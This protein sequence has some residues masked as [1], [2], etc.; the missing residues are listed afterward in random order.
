MVLLIVC[1]FIVRISELAMICAVM[2]VSMNP[3][4]MTLQRPGSAEAPGG[5]SCGP[6]QAVG[7][8]LG[9]DDYVTKPLTWRELAARIQAGL[10]SPGADQSTSLVK[11][12]SYAVLLTP[13][14][15][16]F[17]GVGGLLGGCA[18]MARRPGG[19]RRS[20]PAGPL[21]G[22]RTAAVD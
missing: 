3:G 11:L 1:L 21:A 5:S 19:A 6:D 10:H 14:E 17:R 15:I 22:L 8:E 13:R 18:L 12:S 4:W 2:S 9:A 20:G 7:L 16:A